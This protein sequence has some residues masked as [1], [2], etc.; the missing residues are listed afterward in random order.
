MSTGFIHLRNHTA[1]SLSEGALKIDQLADLCKAMRMPAVAITDTNNLFGAIEF[2]DACVKSGVQPIFG[3][4]LAVAQE[5][6]TAKPGQ[7]EYD[8]I[9]LLAQN[10]TGYLN[11]LALQAL[12]YDQ[13][14]RQMDPH[15]TAASLAELNAGLICLTG[16]GKG[17]LARLLR[18]GQTQK[19]EEFLNFLK[20]SFD[21]RLYIEIQRHHLAEQ[22]ACEAA[23]VDMAYRFNVPLVATNECFYATRDMTDAHDALLCIAQGKLVAD[24]DRRKTTP[25]HYFKSAAEMRQLFADLP[26][27]CDNTIAIAK[28]CSFILEGRAPMLPHFEDGSGL[29]ESEILRNKARE[30]LQARLKCHPETQPKDDSIYK[31]RLEFELDV[32]I[33]MG[34]AGYF[35]I[36][37][38]FI[39][40]AKSQSIPVGP[41]RGSGA[42]SVVAWSLTITD[43]DPLRWG[44]LFERFLNPERVSMP[45]FDI[46]FCQDRRDEVIHYVQSRYGAGRVA[47]IITFGKL[48]ARAVV[49]DVGRVLGMA[50]GHVDKICKLIPN[51]PAA[52]VTLQ[53]AVDTE[54]LMQQMIRE[55][56]AVARLIAM[57]LKLEGLYRHASTHAAGVVIGDRPLRQLIPMYRDPRSDLPV[58]QFSMKYVEKAGLVKFDFLGLK[59]LTVL[60]KTVALLRVQNIDM[61]LERIPLDDRRTYD[62]LC[63]GE[64]TG[65]FQLESSGMR[66]V[67][68]K[69][70]PDRFEDIIAIVALY[71]PGPMDNIPKFIACKQGVEKPDYLHPLLE[72]VLRET[73]GVIIYQEQVMQIAQILSGYTLGGADLL[74]RAMGKKIQAE[75]DAQRQV[76]VDGA[77][78]TNTIAADYANHIFDLVDKFAGYGFNK[79]HAA[80]YALISYQTAYLKANFPAQFMAAQMTLDMGD[81]DK[82]SEF[83]GELRRLQVP[84][85]P[86]DIN[87][88]APDFAVEN[89]AVRYALAALK[90]V[91]FE[92]MKMLCA[93]RASNGRFAD[94]PD[95]M[96]RMDPRA[97]NKRQLESLIC[98]GALDGLHKNRAE[99]IANVESILR[100]AQASRAEQQS[101]QNNLFAGGGQASDFKLTKSNAWNGM[102]RLQREFSSLGYYL[103]AHPLDSYQ[104]LL[105]RLHVTPSTEIAAKVMDKRAGKLT[106]AGVMLSKKERRSQ[107][108]NKY[109]FV[110]F[111]D[112]FGSFEVTFFSEILNASREML[113]AGKPV[114]LT[115]DTQLDGETF[116]MTAQSLRALDDVASE[117]RGNMNIIVE[118]PDAIGALSQNLNSYRQS[119]NGAASKM[120]GKQ[121]KLFLRLEELEVEI[122]LPGYPVPIGP[123]ISDLKSIIGVRVEEV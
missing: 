12:A 102:E 87:A 27:A 47:Q 43:L 36:V 101:N 86:P 93:E 6:K 89:G 81:T 121:I 53:Q 9:V 18:D 105:R 56:E 73:Y 2:S 69:L 3:C 77:V 75:M 83:A 28:R 82:L 39:Q 23:L 71:R 97:I 34:F 123:T 52:P 104:A 54:P 13:V 119:A 46:D 41:G 60:A 32:I 11:L 59:T 64:A 70:K 30:G 65:V 88:S 91:G 111:T 16:G 100:H 103:S 58:T 55:E 15:I 38:D 17:S 72:P 61:D 99:L 63:H 107:K 114:L 8:Q 98:A 42:G 51:N 57:A 50:Y 68:K 66:E 22:N 44:L 29:D 110:D 45:D 31:D 108:G 25:D 118:R 116:R 10:E 120:A 106:L 90:G 40:W 5:D 113:E 85:L 26:E 62:M 19:S 35:L 92:A 76:F 1:Y 7:I 49:R 14:A 109:A 24:S 67:L 122:D 84:L 21:D 79:S 95:L 94:L 20:Q 117:Q 37:A 115:V 96:R 48:Q 33:K 74:R 78:K 112:A 4:Q 80:A